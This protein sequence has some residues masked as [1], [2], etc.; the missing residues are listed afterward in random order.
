[1][2]KGMGRVVLVLMLVAIPG[3]CSRSP[4][5]PAHGG[6]IPWPGHAVC[7]GPHRDGQHPG[8]PDPTVGQIRED[9]DLIRR[10]WR[11]LRMYGACGPAATVLEVIRNENWDLKVMVGA[12]IAPG[13]SAGN[14]AEIEAA[15]ALAHRYPSL[16]WAVCVGNETQVS[17]S[18]HKVP[19]DQLCGHVHLARDSLGPGSH[20]PVTVADDYQF[21]MEPRSRELAAMLDFLTVHAH[22]MWNGKTL[23]EA[24]PWVQVTLAKVQAVHPGKPL[25]LGE[26]GWAT[27]VGPTGEQARLI[28]GTPGERE[29]AEFFRAVREWSASTGLTVF[30]FEAFDEN[31][32]GGDDPREVEKHW[33]VYRADRS[34]KIA[35]EAASQRK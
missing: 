14:R 3:G 5:T 6:A 8:G 16:V 34:E 33:G 18:S 23:E 4:S 24:L 20:V 25:V 32:K 30:Y 21:W 10:H 7:Y 15:T 17:W 13:D 28:L 35:L 1:M 2:M 19:L 9:L 12:W 31:W 11:L 22:P 29:Q 27:S 26:T